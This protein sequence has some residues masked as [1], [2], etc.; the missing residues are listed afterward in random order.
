MRSYH[1]NMWVGCV[2]SRWRRTVA[3]R[4]G[5]SGDDVGVEGGARG[6]MA[7]R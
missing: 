5:E 7:W 1:L 3:G 6:V 2:T 4:E